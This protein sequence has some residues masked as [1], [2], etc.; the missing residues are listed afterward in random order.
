M[1]MPAAVA[2][3]VVAGVPDPTPATI[4][5]RLDEL[6]ELVELHG[7]DHPAQCRR[8]FVLLNGTIMPEIRRR[9][10][11]TLPDGDD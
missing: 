8:L 1:A 6:I 4:A 5:D 11:T 3:P 7:V 9:R 10:T 2:A